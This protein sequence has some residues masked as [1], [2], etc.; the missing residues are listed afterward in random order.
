MPGNLSYTLKLMLGAKLAFGLASQRRANEMGEPLCASE[1]G[2]PRVSLTAGDR[3]TRTFR[4]TPPMRGLALLARGG[5]VAAKRQRRAR[6]LLMPLCFYP[7]YAR[8]EQG[9]SQREAPT[10]WLS[11]LERC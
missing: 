8:A 9:S 5:P 3:R 10:A 11:D 7:H 2:R 4:I 1:A 6:E